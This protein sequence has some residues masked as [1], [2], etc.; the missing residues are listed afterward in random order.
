VAEP[1]TVNTSRNATK[2]DVQV[3]RNKGWMVLLDK[4]RQTRP[5]PPLEHCAFKPVVQ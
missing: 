2:L 3:G 1:T 4:M 5:A